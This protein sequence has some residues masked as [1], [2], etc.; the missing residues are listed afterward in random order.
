M[1]PEE[2]YST[3]KPSANHLWVLGCIA[4]VKIPKAKKTKLNYKGQKCIFI[5]YEDRTMGYKLYYP[6]TKKIIL[7]R[8]VIF[9]EDKA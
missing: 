9:E 6:I 1:T 7:S 4:Y 2:A 5:N 8:D 3:Y